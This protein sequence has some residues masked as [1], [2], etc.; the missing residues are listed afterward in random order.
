MSRPYDHELDARTRRLL[1]SLIAQYL[2]DGEP[3]GSRTLSRSSGLDVSPAT[4]RNIMADLEEAGLVASPHTSAGRIPTPRG[5]RL[6]VDSL[7]ELQPLQH[8]DMAR[9]Q[10]E[11]P[12]GPATTRD[13]L[14]NASSLLSAMTHFAG[15]VTVPRQADFP[16]RHIDFVPLPDARVLVI[17]VFSDNQVQNRVVQLAKPLDGRELEQA[18]NYL[19]AHYVGRRVDDIR[20][21]LLAELRAA[22]SELNR[23]VANATELAT[24]SFAPQAEGDEVLVSGQTNL[25]GYAELADLQRLRELFE[26]FQQKN[27]LLQ[28]MESCA[29]APGVRLFIGEESGFAA[30]DGCSVVTASYG[31]QGRVLGA[32]GVI[33]PTRMAYERVIPVVQATAGLLSD[34]LNRAAT[35]S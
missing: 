9:L 18:A 15:V 2:A 30:L 28:L 1:R 33:G 5:L 32:V 17:L 23:L 11:L 16:L 3:V 29:R 12:P 20:A 13:L 34:A 21:H 10:R 19:N 14:G 26:A 4:I 31:V 25:M 7:I 8:E 24:A 6:F 27:G 35:A 22:G